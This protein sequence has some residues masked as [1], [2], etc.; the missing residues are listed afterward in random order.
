MRQVQNEESKAL[1]LLDAAVGQLV[2]DQEVDAIHDASGDAKAKGPVSTSFALF[3]VV[4]KRPQQQIVVMP[5]SVDCF[6]KYDIAVAQHK[7][8]HKSRTDGKQI[9]RFE[10]D[11]SGVVNGLGLEESDVGEFRDSFL[12]SLPTT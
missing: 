6:T 12:W 1:Q 4:H 5:G 8:R 3:R 9:V 2:K 7:V 11:H 10:L